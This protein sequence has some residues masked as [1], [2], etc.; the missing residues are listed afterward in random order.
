MGKA[1]GGEKSKMETTMDPR[2]SVAKTLRRIY[3]KTN[4]EKSVSNYRWGIESFLKWAGTDDADEIIR[5][6]EAGELDPIEAVQGFIEELSGRGLAPSTVRLY[7]TTA[8]KFFDVNLRTALNWKLLT[9]PTLR[10]VVIDRVPTKNELKRIIDYGDV[11]DKASILFALSSGA[12]DETLAGLNV[13]DVDFEAYPDVALVRVR[14][15][16]AKG[17]VGYPTFI[18]PEARAALEEYLESRHRSGE[19][20]GPDSP[21][22]AHR[23]KRVKPGS[24]SLRWRRRLKSTGLNSKSAGWH[25]LHF[26]VLRKFF[27][28]GLRYISASDRERLMGHKGE[29]LDDAYYKPN[30]DQ[31]LAEYRKAVPELTVYS[32]EIIGEER[33]ATLE[34]ELAET[35]KAFEALKDA[36]VGRMMRELEAKGVDTSKTPH[37]L[38]VEMG[39]AEA[40]PEQKVIDEEGLVAHL[41]EGWRFVAQLNNGS[42]KIVVEK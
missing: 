15:E 31:L 23:G 40:R 9:I 11:R 35:R 18:T 28:T 21:L 17:G 39:I 32:P 1:G 38:A 42:G 34:G 16:I 37:E 20:V 19:D 33:M 5:Q 6:A 7:A 22:F 12:R 41:S 27:R 25:E 29:Y 4:S 3:I 13:G 2:E 24:L 14:A 8:K 10:R 36:T 26:H 30:L